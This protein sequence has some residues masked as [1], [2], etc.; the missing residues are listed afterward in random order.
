MLYKEADLIFTILPGVYP[1]WLQNAHEPLIV[2]V[3]VPFTRRKPWKLSGAPRLLAMERELRGMFKGGE[4]H[5]R[6]VLHKLLK[7][8]RKLDA[9]PAGVVPRLLYL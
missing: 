9:V 7:L 5:P 1:E 2:G 6:S 8:P 4:G 3:C